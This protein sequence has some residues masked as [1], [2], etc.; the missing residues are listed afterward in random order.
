[1]CPL[2]HQSTSHPADMQL[3]LCFCR[4]TSPQRPHT[5]FALC[6]GA[7]ITVV[8]TVTVTKLDPD[9]LST[10]PHDAYVSPGPQ[11]TTFVHLAYL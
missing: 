1:M 9:V 8:E 3:G 5:P 6:G 10:M 7:P 4:L 2:D 11:G